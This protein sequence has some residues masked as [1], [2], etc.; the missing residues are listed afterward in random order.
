VSGATRLQ[1]SWD[2]VAQHGDQVALHFYSHLFLAHPEVR[3][4]FPVGMA[5]QRDRLVTALGRIV[6]DVENHDQLTAFLRQ[7][8]ADHRKFAVVADHY[9]P[10][11]E[12]L[13]ATLAHFLGDRWTAELAREWTAAYGLVAQVMLAGADDAAMHSPPWWEALV[14]RH[15]QVAL[16][17]AVLTVRPRQ[18][19][20]YRPGQSVAVETDLRPRL[21]R[22]YSPAN[23][24]RTDGSLDFH[25]RYVPGGIV[26][27]ALVHTI[28]EGDLVRLGSPVGDN[29]TLDPAGQ[30]DLVLVAGGTGVAPFKALIESNATAEQPRRI[31]LFW[32]GRRPEDL[33]DLPALTALCERHSW[34]QVTACVS[35][36]FRPTDRHEQGT[37]VEVAL[38]HGPWPH[39]DH[40]VCGSPE[41]VQASLT[42]LR[43]AG[44]APERLR[45]EEF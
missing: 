40:Y 5:V 29:L 21:W 24:P 11:G 26:S 19:L 3:D 33:Y 44:V 22:Y 35:D 23:A 13:L 30:R 38:K 36:G 34:L 20:P 9:G 10:V 14:T 1:H 8:G 32:G 28:G 31:H 4:L 18:V 7:L 12:A 25:V 16:D 41:M 39:R 42:H 27:G 2:L 17:L 37:A 45:H 43:E 15:E 6:A